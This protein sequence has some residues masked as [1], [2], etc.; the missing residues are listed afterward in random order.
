M[1]KMTS[2][3][4][5]ANTTPT[6]TLALNVAEVKQR[7]SELIA[8]V[9]YGSETV[10]ITRRGRPMATLAPCR[11]AEGEPHLADVKGW[12]DDTN[13]FFAAVDDVVAS[14]ANHRPRVLASPKRRSRGRRAR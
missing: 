5:K 6:A 9:A 14:R 8:R 1:A 2:M 7:L 10:L 4:R 13:P 3:S 12:L 11:A